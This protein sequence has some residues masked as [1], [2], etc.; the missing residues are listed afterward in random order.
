MTR[1]VHPA[2]RRIRPAG[3]SPTQAPAAFGVDLRGGSARY[4]PGLKPRQ[5]AAAPLSLRLAMT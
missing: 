1:R 4:N 5:R 2:G 3:T